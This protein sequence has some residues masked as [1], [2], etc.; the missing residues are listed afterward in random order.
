MLKIQK[1]DEVWKLEKFDN[2]EFKRNLTVLHTI[3]EDR[4]ISPVNQVQAAFDEAER[5]SQ[6]NNSSNPPGLNV[7]SEKSH[8]AVDDQQ[9]EELLQEADSEI[10]KEKFLQHV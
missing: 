10:S 5:K 1:E 9:T 2:E 6:M 7:I 4:K 3:R 8:F